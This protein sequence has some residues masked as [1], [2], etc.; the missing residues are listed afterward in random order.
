MMTRVRLPVAAL[1]ATLLLA[2]EPRGFGVV[3]GERGAD[4]ELARAC[5][6][7]EKRCSRCHP[8]DRVLDARVSDP[9]DWEAY[10]RRMRQTPGSGIRAGEEPTLVR[11]LVHHSFGPRGAP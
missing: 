7:A 5:R 1:A 3:A 11:C 8:L 10:V 2:C 9:A 4:R 6:L